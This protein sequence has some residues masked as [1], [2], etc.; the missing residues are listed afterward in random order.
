[1]RP[2]PKGGGAQNCTAAARPASQASLGCLPQP[3]QAARLALE[4]PGHQCPPG[5]GD[6]HR[7][8]A[9]LQE[10]RAAIFTIRALNVETSRIAD[11][12]QRG[13]DTPIIQ[14]RFQWWREA[15]AAAL[16]GQPREHPVLLALAHVQPAAQ[17]PRYHLTRLLD[18][19]EADQVLAQPPAS[20]QELELYADGTASQVCVCG[21]GRGGGGAAQLAL[22]AGQGP[23]PPLGWQMER[24]RARRAARRS[25]CPRWRLAATATVASRALPGRRA[26]APSPSHPPHPTLRSQVLHLQLA[27]AGVKDSSADHAASHLGKAVGIAT[28]LKGTLHHSSQRRSYLPLDLCAKHGLSQEA[29]YSGRPSEGA[30]D[31]ALEVASAARGHLQAARRMA[32]KV[33][34]AG[35]G[36]MLQSLACEEYLHRLEQAD[37]D[38]FAPALGGRVASPLAHALRLKWHSLRGTF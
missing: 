17:L 12:V 22:A 20:L 5:A 1:V 34:A 29:L 27:A 31:V 15:V 38:L 14:I 8:A 19:R 23:R 7:G 37:F 36:V 10:L 13:K 24:G 26:L 3:P 28:V 4:L 11:L 32:G 16:R 9:L 21:G 25:P 18:T 30:R 2:A 33:P 6:P 35:R